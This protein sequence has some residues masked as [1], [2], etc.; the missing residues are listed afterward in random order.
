[1]SDREASCMP[2]DLDEA[3]L[4]EKLQ[5]KRIGRDLYLYPEIDSTNSAAFSLGH[6]HAGEG[7]V[8][9]ADSQ[10]QGRGRLRR[11]WQSP[12]GRNLYTSIL[13]KPPIEPSAAPQLTLLAGVAVADLLSSY[14]PGSVRLKWPND[15]QIGGKKVCGILAEM[16]TSG[17][18]IDYVVMGIGI[19]V[20][21]GKGEFDEAFRDLATSLREETGRTL[22]R[23]ELAVGLYE[24][25]EACYTLYL[26]EGFGPLKE[27]WLKFARIVGEQ[28][29]VIFREEI[30]GGEVAGLDDSGA[31]LLR[32]DDGLLRRIIAG[33]ATVKKG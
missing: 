24:H 33:D 16:R 1:V 26:A 20:N 2:T 6:A 21:I 29:E 19:N 7:T 27:R 17:H 31:L 14:C 8:V 25:F 4:K 30:Q 13:L 10:A 32:G 18:G 3:F 15:V 28:I 11:P 5:G 23:Q 9:I 12:P 22:P